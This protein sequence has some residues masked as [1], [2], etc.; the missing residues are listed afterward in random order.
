MP[1]QN[2]YWMLVL[3]LISWLCYSHA[4]QKRRTEYDQLF[5]RFYKA[6]KVIEE[7]YVQQTKPEQ[8]FQ[9]SMRGLIGELDQY[10]AYYTAEEYEQMQTKLDGEFGGIGVQIGLNPETK[11]LTVISP[12]VGTPAYRAGIEAGDKILAIDGTSTEGFLLRDA[13]ELLQGALGDPVTLTILSPGDE[14]PREVELVRDV[15]SVESVLGD[16]HTPDGTWDFLLEGTENIGYIRV[17]NFGSKTTDEL[18]AA[19][20]GLLQQGVEGLVLDLRNNPG[21]LLTQAVSVSDLFIEEGL[22]VS[23]RG[24]EKQPSDEYSATSSGTYRDIPLVVLV[25]NFS[26]SASEIV[27]ACLQDHKRA[28]IVGE[29]TWGKGSVQH[30]RELGQDAIKITIATYHRPSGKNIHR[31]PDAKESDAWGVEPDPQHKVK[32]TTEQTREVIAYRRK[33]DVISRSD[34]AVPQDEEQQKLPLEVDPQLKHAVEVLQDL[35]SPVAAT[36]S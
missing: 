28:V 9:G 33:R 34:D 4:D 2:V 7:E 15:I 21:G 5:G 18:R 14:E 10:S 6:M 12:L 26:A 31:L 19:I 27:A 25:N 16:R 20:D 17:T 8:L 13:V 3:L 11:I 1:R 23:T 30:V 35:A 24:R 36:A 32:L 29:R 22:I